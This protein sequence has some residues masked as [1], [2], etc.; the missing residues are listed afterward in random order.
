MKGNATD[1]DKS[2]DL[3]I[4]DRDDLGTISSMKLSFHLLD[5]TK[6]TEELPCLLRSRGGC[7]WFSDF[8]ILVEHQKNSD[9]C[10]LLVIYRVVVDRACCHAL[11]YNR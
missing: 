8:F 7:S 10:A 9:L 4:H 5:L 1:A 11:D 3:Q 2:T 6:D